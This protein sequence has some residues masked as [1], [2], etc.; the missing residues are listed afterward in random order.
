M[1]NASTLLTAS[2]AGFAGAVIGAVAVLFFKGRFIRTAEVEGHAE[3]TWTPRTY[4]TQPDL[5]GITGAQAGLHARAT[6]VLHQCV[7][8][9]DGLRLPSSEMER[10]YA[11]SL[12]SVVRAQLTEIVH[13]L[14][15][16]GGPR[17]P[18]VDHLFSMLLGCMF[19]TTPGNVEGLIGELV[20]IS[21]SPS[22]WSIRLE[23]SKTSPTSGS[24]PI[25][26]PVCGRVGKM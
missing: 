19:T 25:T 24:L 13:E 20:Y 23:T 8:L 15:R 22:A 18:R 14:G 9:L 21:A 2:L 1:D 17:V 11:G 3:S 12:R 5:G 6:A 26:L 7:P 10:E 4:S 16:E